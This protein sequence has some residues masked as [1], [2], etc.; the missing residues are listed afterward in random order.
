MMKREWHNAIFDPMRLTSSGWRVWVSKSHDVT[1]T[2]SKKSPLRL[3]KRQ[4]LNLPC[5]SEGH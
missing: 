2:K 3:Q 5:R 4:S 1:K